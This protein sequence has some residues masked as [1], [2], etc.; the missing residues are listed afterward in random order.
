MSLRCHEPLSQRFLRVIPS[1]WTNLTRSLSTILSLNRLGPPRKVL[2]QEKGLT[3]ARLLSQFDTHHL[4]LL[5][6][7]KSL[8]SLE[9]TT[10]LLEGTEIAVAP[11][12]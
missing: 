12:L 7:R 9:W 6:S 1:R 3:A 4:L 5:R 8:P 2:S 11:T 10:Q